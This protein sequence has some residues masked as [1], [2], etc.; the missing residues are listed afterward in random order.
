MAQSSISVSSFTERHFVSKYIRRAEY[1][2]QEIFNYIKSG[3]KKLYVDGF[4][5]DLQTSRL[6]TFVE[7]GHHCINCGRK[8]TTF[9]VEKHINQPNDDFHL[10][11]YHVNKNGNHYLMT[12]DHI[13]PRSKGGSDELDNSQTMCYE[14]NCIKGNKV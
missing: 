10:N 3:S 6:R 5:I 12:R 1:E 13:Y 7:K 8:G 9:Y 11:L 14:C 4:D 2:P